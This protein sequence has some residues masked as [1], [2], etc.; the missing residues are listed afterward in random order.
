[1][2][3]SSKHQTRIP[4]G[5]M[6]RLRD[7]SPSQGLLKSAMTEEAPAKTEEAPERAKRLSTFPY[8]RPCL[9]FWNKFFPLVN[10]W[11]FAKRKV[12]PCSFGRR[13]SSKITLRKQ[14]Q[15]ASWSRGMIRASGA[16]GPGFKSRTGPTF[17]RCLDPR[18]FRTFCL[19]PFLSIFFF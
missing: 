8:F 10:L 12:M 16:R 9:M 11:V 3:E 19:F 6:G 15:Q 17:F 4:D 2:S 18:L 14:N 1:M 13:N 5:N 7:V